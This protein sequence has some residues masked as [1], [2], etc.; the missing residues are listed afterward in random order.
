MFHLI[1]ILPQVNPPPKA[2]SMVLRFALTFIRKSKIF[3]IPKLLPRDIL[4]KYSNKLLLGFD[5][6]LFTN[7]SLNRNFGDS[8]HLLPVNQNLVD[9]VSSKTI[10]ATRNNVFYTLV[11]KVV[12]ESVNS[13]INRLILYLNKK[14]IDNSK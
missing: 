9:A 4:K 13:K 8:C 3:E 2:A 10:N 14:N 1:N 12:G 11:N 6:K 7:S 5:P